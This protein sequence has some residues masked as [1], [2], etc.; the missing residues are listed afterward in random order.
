LLEIP[1]DDPLLSKKQ[2]L[3]NQL[4]MKRLANRERERERERN[5]GTTTTLNMS[6]FLLLA[7]RI[8]L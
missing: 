5:V 6:L 3:L 7:L 1:K 4:G 2:E 8:F